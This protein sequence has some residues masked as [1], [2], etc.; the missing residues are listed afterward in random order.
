[1]LESP[2][3]EIVKKYKNP[4][5]PYEV[6]E[7]QKSTR[8]MFQRRQNDVLITVGTNYSVA[9]GIFERSRR[10]Q[11]GCTYVLYKKYSIGTI[12][13]HNMDYETNVAHGRIQTVR[14]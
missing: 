6:P 1:M 9:V 2:A 10:A 14:K 3:T 8:V 5:G 13:R 4:E 7:V 11:S 12:R